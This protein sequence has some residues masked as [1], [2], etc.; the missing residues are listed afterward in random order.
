[1]NLGLKGRS[2]LVTGGTSGIGAAT[3]ALLEAEGAA[4][5]RTGRDALD[6]TDPRAGERALE[7]GPF[8]VLV[9]SAGTSHFAPLDHLTDADWQAQWDLH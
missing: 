7:L 4:V 3:A 9:N 5:T 2:A 6:V 8:D 1:M